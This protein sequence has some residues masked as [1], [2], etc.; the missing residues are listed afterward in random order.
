MI[1][2]RGKGLRFKDTGTTHLEQAV[3]YEAVTP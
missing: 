1:L 2:R 3:N